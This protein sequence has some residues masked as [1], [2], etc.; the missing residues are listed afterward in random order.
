MMLTQTPKTAVI[1]LGNMGAGKSTLL[2]QIGGKFPSGV[3]FMTG[4][5]KEV[6]EQVVCLN[7]EPVILIDTP[8]LY[9]AR[10]EA[11]KANAEKMTEALRKGYDY[12]IF[13]VLK[14][15]N[16]G[17]TPEDLS[18]M[19][20]VSKC[21]QQVNGAKVEYRI[22]INQI[23][24]DKVYD[25]YEERVAKDNFRGIIEVIRDEYELDIEVSGV[26]LV[27]S[28]E[29]AVNEMRLRESIAEQ[30]KTHTSFQIKVMDI[31]ADNSD[32]SLLAGIGCLIMGFLA[33]GALVVRNK[34]VVMSVVTNKGF[35]MNALTIAQTL[36]ELIQKQ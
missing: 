24:S 23:E 1:F 18:L 19:S 15:S 2:S 25:M 33:I 5:T 36:M 34:A 14:A 26:M 27:R 31:K 16:R 29:A 28:D 9:E 17:I 13:I 35:I 4:L 3:A 8:G 10:N 22:I 6:T 21:V 32:L 7:G 11:T 30:I 12:K 20:K